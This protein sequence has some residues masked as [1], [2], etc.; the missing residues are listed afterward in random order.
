MLN[1]KYPEVRRFYRA[2]FGHLDAAGALLGLCPV[3]TNSTRGHEVVYLCGYVVECSLKAVLM[4]RFPRSQHDEVA[5][6]FKAEVKHKFDRLKV[7]LVDKGVNIPA[8]LKE[9]LKRIHTNWNS[10]MRYDVRAWR[11]DA[12]MRIYDSAKRLFDWATGG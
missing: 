2:A 5:F 8:K 6:W 3:A 11:K 10:E 12:V 7:E 4:S 9:D 1:L